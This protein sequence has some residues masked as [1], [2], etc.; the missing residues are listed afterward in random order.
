MYMAIARGIAVKCSKTNK[1]KY[2][3]MKTAVKSGNVN[4]NSTCTAR[5]HLPRAKFIEL[6]SS[7][8]LS[9]EGEACRWGFSDP[10]GSEYKE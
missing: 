6:Y 10:N 9:L 7:V 3:N 5:K 8:L 2:E 1:H 4:T